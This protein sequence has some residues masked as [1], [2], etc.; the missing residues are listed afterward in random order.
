MIENNMK[1]QITYAS[2]S[3]RMLAAFIDIIIITIF[4]SPLFKITTNFFY[5]KEN[6]YKK[7]SSIELSIDKKHDDNSS[8]SDNKEQK[9]YNI[10]VKEGYLYKILI[11][12]VF[13]SFILLLLFTFYLSKFSTTPGKRLLSLIVVDAESLNKPS[14]KQSFTRF[15]GYFI[16]TIPLFIGIFSIKF[17]KKSQGFHDRI[18][19]T[20]VIKK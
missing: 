6:L 14:I 8:M 11:D 3:S 13:Q 16:S 5:D 2:F 10:M 12:I 18:A 19:N 1:K 4:L 15:I 20:I 17:N 7:M 9:I